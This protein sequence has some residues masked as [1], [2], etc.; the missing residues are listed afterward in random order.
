MIEDMKDPKTEHWFESSVL[1]GKW[2]QRV[3]TV[4]CT[5]AAKA[6]AMGSKA[7]N[8]TPPMQRWEKLMYTARFHEYL[9]H[10]TRVG[11]EWIRRVSYLRFHTF[12]EMWARAE[13]DNWSE[14]E[15]LLII[16]NWEYFQW[17]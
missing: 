4:P 7:Y 1:G 12:E 8:D 3:H 14:K 9:K 6:R 13:K 2:L 15:A 10:K 17:Q 16:H 5:V 11:H